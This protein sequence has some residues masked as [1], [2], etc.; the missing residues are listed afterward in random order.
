MRST[1]RSAGKSRAQTS[2]TA[3][4]RQPPTSTAGALDYYEIAARQNGHD[5]LTFVDELVV[6]RGEATAAPTEETTP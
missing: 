5:W 4:V 1:S 6:E 2:V 3:T